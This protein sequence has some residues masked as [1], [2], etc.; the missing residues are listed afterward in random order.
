M[1]SQEDRTSALLRLVKEGDASASEQLFD[2]LYDE[3]HR[4]A[5]RLRQGRA[6]ETMNTTALVHEAYIKLVSADGFDPESR[7]HFVRTAAR[8]MRQILVDAARRKLAEK[9]GGDQFPVTFNDAV[10]SGPMAAEKI[11]SLDRALDRL[12]AVD[13]R[14][15]QVVECRYFAGLTVEETATA[16]GVAPRTVKR[17]W[18]VARAFLTAE[19]TV[20]DG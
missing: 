12:A 14:A 20:A 9:R 13:T 5:K 17:D 7:L 1:D 18:R 16:V 10:H 15:A 6:G 2:A 19:L 8:V 4:L 11:L 3:L